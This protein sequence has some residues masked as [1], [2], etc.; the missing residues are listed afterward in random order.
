MATPRHP[1]V[2]DEL[3]VTCL[4]TS[5]LLTSAERNKVVRKYDYKYLATEKAITAIFI[6]FHVERNNVLFVAKSSKYTSF[7]SIYFAAL[8][9]FPKAGEGIDARAVAANTAARLRT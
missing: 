8:L 5:H 9:V 3:F 2:V 6:Q 1:D 4:P 7:R